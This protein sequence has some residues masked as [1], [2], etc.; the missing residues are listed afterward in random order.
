MT[1][2]Q[3][4]LEIF[5]NAQNDSIGGVYYTLSQDPNNLKQYLKKD[6]TIKTKKNETNTIKFVL[7]DATQRLLAFTS[8]PIYLSENSGCPNQPGISNG[9]QARPEMDSGGK[10]NP[11]CFYLDCPA[12]SARQVYGYQLNIV[13]KDG[14][15]CPFDPVIENG[16]G[17]G[18]LQWENLLVGLFGLVVGIGLTYLA[19]VMGWIQF[20]R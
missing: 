19:G 1:K 6:G 4:D 8:D 17:Q 12:A 13:A 3:H 20:T 9:F 7:S 11:N 5:V 18:F 16:G 15:P 10:V 2:Q 14:T